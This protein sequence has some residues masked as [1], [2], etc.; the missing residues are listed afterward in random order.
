MADVKVQ[1]ILKVDATAKML[2]KKLTK[3]MKHDVIREKN[4]DV[5]NKE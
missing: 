5:S 4:A 3:I 1:L 2:T